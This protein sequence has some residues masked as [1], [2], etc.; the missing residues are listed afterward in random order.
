MIIHKLAKKGNDNLVFLGLPAASILAFIL[1]SSNALAEVNE[2]VISGKSL[3]KELSKNQVKDID[4]KSYQKELDRDMAKWTND[5]EK[6]LNEDVKKQKPIEEFKI[7]VS[8]E[9]KKIANEIVEKS[10][11]LTKEALGISG[12]KSLATQKSLNTDFLIFASFGSVASIK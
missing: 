5:L 3:L 9:S 8:Q 4:T 10:Q 7:E 6:R 11:E 12:D 1:L 2:G